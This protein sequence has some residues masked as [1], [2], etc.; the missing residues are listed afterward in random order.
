M[1]QSSPDGGAKRQIKRQNNTWHHVAVIAAVQPRAVDQRLKGVALQAY[2]CG[3][4]FK[5]GSR[6]AV[7]AALVDLTL[8]AHG[9]GITS[10]GG[11]L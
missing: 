4:R 6:F 1:M 7:V 2:A 11:C 9:S 3:D 10:P 8:S 5:T